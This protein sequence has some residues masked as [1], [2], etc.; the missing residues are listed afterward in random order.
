VAELPARIRSG[1]PR[2]LLIRAAIA[3][4]LSLAIVQLI[5]GSAAA[6][7]DITFMITWFVLTGR[8]DLAPP[9]ER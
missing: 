6:P 4:V 2:Q 3:A 8:H 9:P 5:P 7:A 1:R